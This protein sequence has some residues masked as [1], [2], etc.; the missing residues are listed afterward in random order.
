MKCPFP[1]SISG[2]HDTHLTIFVKVAFV[3]FSTVKLL[4]F[5]SPAVFFRTVSLSLAHPWSRGAGRREVKLHFRGEAGIS[6]Y[7]LEFFS[8]KD[9]SVLPSFICLLIQSFLSAWIHAY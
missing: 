5:P 9:L 1:H 4:F 8:K 3:G 6:I 7:Y 2:V